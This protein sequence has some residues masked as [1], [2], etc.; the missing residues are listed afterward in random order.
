MSSDV[1]IAK[2]YISLVVDSSTNNLGK[3]LIA[4]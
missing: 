4:T 2:Y 3:A 1:M